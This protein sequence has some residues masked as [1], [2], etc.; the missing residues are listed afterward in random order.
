MIL[1][2]MMEIRKCTE[3]DFKLMSQWWKSF[4]YPLIPRDSYPELTFMATLNGEPLVS[5]SMQLTDSKMVFCEN[6]ISKPGISNE[7]RANAIDLLLKNLIFNSKKR[8]YKYWMA[9]TKSKGMMN[10][11][12]KI[13]MNQFFENCYCITGD[14]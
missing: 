6:F 3:D 14:L 12:K 11:G 10:R 7:I 13:K 4:G 8:G 9:T 2:N 1:G 5:G